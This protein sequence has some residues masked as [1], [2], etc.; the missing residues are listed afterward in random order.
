MKISKEIT[1]GE[2]IRNYPDALEVLSR[3]GINDVSSAEAQ[4]EQIGQA[5]EEQGIEVNEVI[6]ALRENVGSEIRW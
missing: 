3:F 1:I 2:V 4:L 6:K 5:C